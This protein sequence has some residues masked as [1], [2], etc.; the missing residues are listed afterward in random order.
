[1][2]VKWN[3]N[4]NWLLTASRDHLVKLFDVRN[5]KEEMQAFKGHRKEATS[6]YDEPSRHA[7]TACLY[8]ESYDNCVV[9]IDD[10]YVVVVLQRSRGIRY[11]S[12][13]LRVAART[14][15]FSTGWSGK[16]CNVVSKR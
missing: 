2:E 3:A 5:M 12:R 15:R 10:D 9:A 7:H 1:M 14:G 4:G 6:T 11:T 16:R 13:C 8:D